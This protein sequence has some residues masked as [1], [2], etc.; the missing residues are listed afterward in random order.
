[1]NVSEIA[2]LNYP[3]SLRRRVKFFL[4]VMLYG[5]KCLTKIENV[6]NHPKLHR[7]I[8]DNPGQYTK[9]FRPYLYKGLRMQGRILAI[10]NHHDFIKK[11]WDTKLIYSVYQKKCFPLAEIKFDQGSSFSILLEP[12]G[13]TRYESEGEVLI[14]LFSK[15][16]I[17]SACFNFTRNK[18]G[19]AG[20]FVSSMQGSS[21]KEF[22]DLNTVIKDF[23]KKTGGMRPHMFLLYALTVIISIYDLKIFLA[24]KTDA[25]LKSKRIKA[26]VDSFWSDFG[27]EIANKFSYALP[28]TYQ[29]KPI[30]E[31]KTN[32]RAM[33]RQRYQIL[34]S[35]EQ[36]IRSALNNQ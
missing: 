25:H 2:I 7:I 13:K 27:G 26:N 33:Y 3:N 34:D 23:T 12:T 36:Q 29:R 10:N 20:I 5:K 19:E 17:I 21:N 14:S 28:L 18:K 15:E 9:I 24:I 11:Q 8:I 35:V 30:E 32:K 6:F 31:V 22:T 1:M 16:K 4:R